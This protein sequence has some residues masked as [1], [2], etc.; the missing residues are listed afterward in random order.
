[1]AKTGRNEPCPCGSGKKYKACCLDQDRAVRAASEARGVAFLSSKSQRSLEVRDAA[2]WSVARAYVPVAEVWRSTGL[3]TAGIV[4]RQ[5]GDR[6]AYALFSIVLLERGIG[7]MVGKR[8]MSSQELEE[9][10][11]DF[12]SLVPPFEEGPTELAASFVWGARAFGESEGVRF[13]PSREAQF[14]ALV[15]RPPGGA[16]Q[17]R[18]RLVGRGGLTPPRLMRVIEANPVELELPQNMEVVI[19]TEMSFDLD[20]AAAVAARTREIPPAYGGFQFH[21]TEPDEGEVAFF[22]WVRPYP[23]GH[24]SPLKVLGGMQLLGSVRIVEGS[25][26]AEAK[27]LSMAARLAGMLKEQLGEAIRLRETRWSTPEDLRQTG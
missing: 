25:L 19:F 6:Y 26:V 9:E 11:A 17:W 8:D 4:R 1:M 13:P 18:E 2:G 7:V 12:R 23:K 22:E 10:I 14:L 27:S 5:P 24:W 16:R 20:D 15:P 3:G 21:E